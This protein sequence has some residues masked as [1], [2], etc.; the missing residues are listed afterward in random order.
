M[1]EKT[2]VSITKKTRDRMKKYGFLNSTY[3]SVINDLIDHVEKCQD[4]W[5]DRF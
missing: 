2:T 3:D 5:R 1:I 4:W